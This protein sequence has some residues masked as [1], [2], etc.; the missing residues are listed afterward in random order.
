MDLYRRMKFLENGSLMG[1]ARWTDPIK[2]FE[3]REETRK[4]KL[5]SP[6][7]RGIFEWVLLSLLTGG[8]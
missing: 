3:C 4:R 6:Y 1:Y 7:L 8:F 2:G 5:F